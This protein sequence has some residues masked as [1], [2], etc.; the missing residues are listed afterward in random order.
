[1]RITACF[2]CA[3]LAAASASAETLVYFGTYTAGQ[4]SS[5]GIYVSEL[6]ERTGELSPPRLA[7]TLP[8][9]SFVALHPRGGFVYAVSES[10]GQAPAR[11]AAFAIADDGTLR[12]LNRRQTGG[13]GACHVAVD[14]TGR[15]VGVAN[16][17]GGSCA[18]FPLNDDGSLGPRGSFHQ[19]QGSSVNPRRQ[20]APHAHSIN[21]NADGT[22]AFVADLGTDEILIYDVNA[23]EGTMESAEQTSLKVPA[24][25]GPRHF[26]FVPDGDLALTNLEMTS[27]VALL[28]YD[29]EAG[30]LSLGPVVSTLPDGADAEGNSTAECL[31]HP[32]GRTAYVSNRG[33]NSI[34]VFH[35]DARAGSLK[36]VGHQST[37]GEIPRGF[38]IDPSGRFLVAANQRSGNVVTLRIDPETGELR[39]TG[40]SI[41]LDAPVNVRFLQR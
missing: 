29:R 8:N 41:R 12:L 31:V 28:R 15:C 16:Y 22:Q 21:F 5:E 32:N 10:R 19:H 3:V 6:D 26:C 11:V 17:G 25:G 20:T 9:P 27:Q 36:A 35:I 7:A 4:S 34:A 14:P 1:M 30:R 2:L 39:S 24:G 37:E 40:H 18:S 23:T 33:H 38:G 13:P